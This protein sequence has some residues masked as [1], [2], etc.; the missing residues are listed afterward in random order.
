MSSSSSDRG[1]AAAGIG[2][3]SALPVDMRRQLVGRFDR[4]TLAAMARASGDARSLASGANRFDV[5]ACCR[6]PP[7]PRELAAHI[8]ERIALP[9]AQHL[10]GDVGSSRTLT[11]TTAKAYRLELTFAVV[12]D[13]DVTVTL[14]GFDGNVED[15]DEAEQSLGVAFVAY[16]DGDDFAPRIVDAA[17]R[18]CRDAATVIPMIGGVEMLTTG[19]GLPRATMMYSENDDDDDEPSPAL[20]SVDHAA[21][22]I[23]FAPD[24]FRDVL[25]RRMQTPHA[26]AAAAPL[27]DRCVL[28]YAIA[29]TWA[30][31]RFGAER[32]LGA[33][34][35]TSAH[36]A[37][38]FAYDEALLRNGGA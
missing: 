34:V 32:V 9:I 26:C 13:G 30:L 23:W 5:R 22:T 18:V 2:A 15:L 16:D 21:H 1:G 7:S 25:R 6:K 17:Q 3:L 27:I 36:D 31:C 10:R 19:D 28:A 38:T 20:R 29:S 12:P 14:D 4:A 33:A 11:W 8:Y 35:A 37:A 24:V